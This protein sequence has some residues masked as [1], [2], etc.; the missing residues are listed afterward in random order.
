[1]NSATKAPLNRASLDLEQVWAEYQQ[2]LKSF[3][4]SKVNNSA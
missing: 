4:Y 1:M 3:L 2:A